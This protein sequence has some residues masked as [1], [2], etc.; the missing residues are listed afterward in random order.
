MQKNVLIVHEPETLA[1]AE[2]LIQEV[3]AIDPEIEL[4]TKALAPPVDEAAKEP[5]A[6]ELGRHAV[7]LILV[8]EATKENPWYEFVVEKGAALQRGF[9]GVCVPGVDWFSGPEA[10]MEVAVQPIEWDTQRIVEDIVEVAKVTPDPR[11]AGDPRLGPEGG[12]DDS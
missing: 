3:R 2:K 8:G 7:I 12:G 9:M 10:L 5:L 1:Q 11:L 6:Q 4:T